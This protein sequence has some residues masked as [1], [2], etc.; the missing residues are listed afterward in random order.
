MS[1]ARIWCDFDSYP[2]R[3]HLP[4][5]VAICLAVSILLLTTANFTSEAA[6]T[7]DLS[8][9]S[10]AFVNEVVLIDARQSVNVSKLPQA[11]GTPSVN[12]DFGDGF[13]ANLL[14]TGHAYRAP[15]T[16]TI[17]LTTKNNSGD[18]ATT[19]RTIVVTPLPLATGSNLQVL[20]NTGVPL[21][22]GIALQT[23]INA[24]ALGN[25]A[26]QEI[27]LPAGAV[28]AGPIVLPA[29]VGDKYITIR[30]GS[31]PSLPASGNRVGP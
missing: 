6:L 12:I 11:D 18:V 10:S 1:I 31:L 16:Y 8:A 23:A 21:Q 26:E 27:V 4:L 14:A 19:Q 5:R 20:V 24:A 9:P 30:S 13:S 28:F 2:G 3:F 17:T 22:N 7:L 25:C 29:P 15:G